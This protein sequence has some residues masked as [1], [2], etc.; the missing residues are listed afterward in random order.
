MKILLLSPYVPVSSQGGGGTAYY[1]YIK[2]LSRQHEIT[3]LCLCREDNPGGQEELA[4]FCRRIDVRRIDKSAAYM[5]CVAA[6][7]RGKS[8]RVAYY[9]SPSFQRLVG[10]VIAT[11]HFDV[12]LASH[13]RMGQFVERSSGVKKVIDLHDV[14]SFR[15]QMLA[16]S[17]RNPLL[18]AVHSWESVKL[19]AYERRC[20]R[21]FDSVWLC[22]EEE[23]AGLR[24]VDGRKCLR[25]ASRGIDLS[26]FPFGLGDEASNALVFTGNMSY[27][28]NVEGALFFLQD[29]FPLLKKRL[30]QARFVIV[31]NYPHA[32]IR[33]AAK[34]RKDVLVTGRVPSVAEYL[35]HGRVFIGSLRSGTGARMKILEAMAVGLPV[36]S[37]SV[38]CAGLGARPGEHLLV[39]DAPGDFARAVEMLF[40]DGQLHASISRNGRAFVERHFS[41]ARASAVADGLL[42]EVVASV[43]QRN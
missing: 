33:R 34:G 40:V 20:L 1:Y 10:E 11:G 16:K 31:G 8:L 27:E 41:M 22:T 15:H 9:A 14:V 26:D 17:T 13:E 6:L 21:V 30:P 4:S 3:L 2:H 42:A 18:K 24:D 19:A 29:V 23:A 32:K 35:K 38:G 39:A 12:V 37:T 43:D 36:V 25:V 5:N 7:V 28:P